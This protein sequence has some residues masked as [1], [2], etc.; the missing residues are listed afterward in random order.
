M[1]DA[2]HVE[3]VYRFAQIPEA[4]VYDTRL[5]D[6]AVR[7]YAALH[8]HGSDPTNCYP[9]YQRLGA[10]IGKSPRS[11]PKLVDQ[12]ATLGW[13]EV[14]HRYDQTGQRSNGYRLLTNPEGAEMLRP[15]ME[16][17]RGAA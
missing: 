12:L 17:H 6:G 5:P 4:L 3:V 13:I 16:M 15:P 1:T 10:L 9:S 14:V 7:L 8:R 11:I 2:P